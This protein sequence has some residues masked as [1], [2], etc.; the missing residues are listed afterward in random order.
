MNN[1]IFKIQSKI[2]ETIQNEIVDNNLLEESDF[3]LRSFLEVIVGLV[4]IKLL[5][6]FDSIIDD[7]LKDEDMSNEDKETLSL[8]K[9]I[10]G[11]K[12]DR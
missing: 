11:R 7:A 1:K 6:R 3:E 4:G 12:D 10:S 5:S 2:A 9:S 8:I